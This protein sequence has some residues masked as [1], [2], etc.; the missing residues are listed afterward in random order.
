M[1][2]PVSALLVVVLCLAC[3]GT[4]AGPSPVDTGVWGGDHVT[5]SVS[6]SGT[7]LEFDCA[8]GDIP[9]A[10][11]AD[12]GAIASTGTYVREHGG[13]I[14]VDEPMDVHPALYSGSLS[15]G[16]MSLSIRL[17]DSGDVVGPFDLVHGTAGRVFKCL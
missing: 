9:G 5:M 12:H 7:H 1:R 3:S 14:R 11:S 17:T 8:H 4:P 15:N 10:L 2:V 13:P 16:R 6:A